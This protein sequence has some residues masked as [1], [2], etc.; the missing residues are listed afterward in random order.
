MD[1]RT[2]LAGA[3]TVLVAA[4]LVAEAQQPAKTA[5]I[6]TFV[7]DPVGSGLVASLTRPSGN[8]TGLSTLAA[9]LVAKR[10]DLLKTLV[11]GPKRMAVLGEP[12][13]FAERTIR[14][15]REETE[16]AA[17]ALAVRVQFMYGR[18]ASYVN[19][20]LTDAM[21]ADLPIEE[22]TKF[23][24]VVNLETAKTLGLTIPPALL[25]RA[26]EVIQ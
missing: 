23:E 3:G 20:I 6:V 21:P 13:V 2:F 14:S 16:V 8:I 5:R 9:G 4:P 25:G 18:A 15:M 12:D 22:P 10:L 11:P 24:L 7:A 26:D 17:R 19:R 1:R